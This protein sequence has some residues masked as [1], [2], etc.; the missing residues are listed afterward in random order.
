MV[1]EK[2]EKDPIKINIFDLKEQSGCKR[3][4]PLEEGKAKR[5]NTRSEVHGLSL[6]QQRIGRVVGHNSLS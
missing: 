6:Y 4:S 3:F 5:K 1:V 2:Q